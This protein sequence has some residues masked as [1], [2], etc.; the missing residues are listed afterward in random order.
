[1]IR[2]TMR[3]SAPPDGSVSITKLASDI[4][5][6]A[7]DTLTAEDASEARASL[8]LGDLATLDRADLGLWTTVAKSVDT[9]R[10]GTTT[11]AD[12]PHLAIGLLAGTKYAIRGVVFFDAPLVPGFK[13]AFSGPAAPTLVRVMRSSIAPGAAVLGGIAVDAAYTVSTTIAGAAAPQGVLEFALIVHNGANAGSLTFQWAQSV[14]SGTAATV[15]A[16]SF[17]DWRVA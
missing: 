3:T 16:G 1:M 4:S 15:Y 17:L 13:W 2:N 9:A 14:S 5:A 12:D 6:F 7:K 10:S 8:E 11:L